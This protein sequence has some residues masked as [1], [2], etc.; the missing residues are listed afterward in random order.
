MSNVFSTIWSTQTRS[1]ACR[2]NMAVSCCFS[3][4]NVGRFDTDSFQHFIITAYLSHDSAEIN[5][6]DPVKNQYRKQKWHGQINKKRKLISR[7]D[8]NNR[9]KRRRGWEGKGGTLDPHNVGNRL[10]PLQS[11]DVSLERS[12]RTREVPATPVWSHLFYEAYTFMG[13]SH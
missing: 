1:T 5:G 2:S 6:V 7:Y 13:C 8:T 11:T 12:T 3:T 9:R 10:T 4:E